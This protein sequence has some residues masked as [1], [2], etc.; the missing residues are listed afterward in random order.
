MDVQ[1]IEGLRKRL[2]VF[3]NMFSDCF[4]RREPQEHLQTYVQGQL[5]DLP[6]KS[7]EPIALAAGLRGMERGY[8]LAAPIED[9]VFEMDA[10]MQ[11][12][13]GIASLPGNLYDAV[14][15]AEK[16][17]LVREALGDHVFTK[18]IANKKIEWDRYR[19]QVSKYEIDRYLPIL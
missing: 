18:F 16:S 15:L 10:T 12:D 6:R 5:S 2:R 17:D 4:G 1:A 14:L 9:N 11:S 3:L 13:H 7:I 8:K 19:I